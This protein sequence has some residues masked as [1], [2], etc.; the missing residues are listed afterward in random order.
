MRLKGTGSEMKAE[1]N[2]RWG[3]GRGDEGG[4]ERGTREVERGGTCTKEV[5]SGGEG[6]GR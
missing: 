1:V 6:R 2:R 4:G 3:E 5:E